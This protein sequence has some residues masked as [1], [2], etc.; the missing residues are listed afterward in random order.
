MQVENMEALRC[1]DSIAGAADA[2]ILSRGNLGLDVA[3]EKTAV[4]QKAAVNRCNLLVPSPCC[5]PIRCR[6]TGRDLA[7]SAVQLNDGSS[8][9]NL[10]G[11]RQEFLAMCL[12]PHL[13]YWK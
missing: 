5:C 11:G 2:I 7:M 10:E 6:S 1:F 13:K 9:Y 12:C 3:P 8:R 4:V